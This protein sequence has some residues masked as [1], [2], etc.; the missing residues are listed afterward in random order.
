MVICG[1]TYDRSQFTDA[2]IAARERGV[3]I[4]VLIDEGYCKGSIPQSTQMKRLVEAGCLVFGCKGTTLRDEY[5]HDGR[6]DVAGICGSKKGIMHA[7]CARRDRWFLCGSTNHTTSSR[8][9][10]ER[11]CL[12]YLDKQAEEREYQKEK[13]VIQE[14]S[15]PWSVEDCEELIRKSRNRSESRSRSK[16]AQREAEYLS[17]PFISAASAHDDPAMTERLGDLRDRSASRRYVHDYRHTAS[18]S[19]RSPHRSRR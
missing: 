14:H 12:M 9:N 19:S 3:V 13:L 11:S 7:K 17:E 8:G 2:L 4:Q 5:Q 1:F 15:P 18:R 6:M 16:T 10:H